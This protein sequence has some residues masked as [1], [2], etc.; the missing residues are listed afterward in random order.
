MWELFLAKSK[1]LGFD[2]AQFSLHC[3]R[4][5]GASAASNAGIR[6]R[7]FKG[8]GCWRLESAKDGYVKDSQEALLAVSKSLNL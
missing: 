2:V 1:E 7:L 4:A 8:H 3:L 6:D 5:I